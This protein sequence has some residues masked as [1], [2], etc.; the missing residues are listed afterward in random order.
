LVTRPNADIKLSKNGRIEVKFVLGRA[1]RLD[2]FTVTARSDC[3]PRTLNGFMCRRRTGGGVFLD[4]A[5]IDE[6]AANYTADLF[7]DIEGFRVD[8]RRTR[9]GPVPVPVRKGFGCITSLVDGREVT[10]ANPV[11]T[12]PADLS[13]VEVYLRP[14]S[15]PLP[16]QRY[17]W[18]SNVSR[19]G[20]CSVIVYWTLWAPVT[21]PL[22]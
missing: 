10:P 22:K 6:R 1:V 14:D 2:T 8:L 12:H 21:G 13:A 18:T 16:Y 3:P 17:T 4:Y 15:V 19:T 11:P 9:S 20:R 7:K 5:D